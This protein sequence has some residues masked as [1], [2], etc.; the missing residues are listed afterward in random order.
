MYTRSDF[1][2]E[3]HEG[4]YGPIWVITPVGGETLHYVLR[5]TVKMYEE[6]GNKLQGSAK[7]HLDTTYSKNPLQHVGGWHGA[8][9]TSDMDEAFDALID[10]I[11]KND[12]LRRVEDAINEPLYELREA[13]GSLDEAVEPFAKYDVEEVIDNIKLAVSALVLRYEQ[14]SKEQ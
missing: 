1:T 9:L 4:T 3:K 5:S 7:I 10:D 12:V 11:N 14:A 13:L 6:P 2:V 8:Y